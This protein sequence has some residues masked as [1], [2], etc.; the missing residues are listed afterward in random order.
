MMCSGIEAQSLLCAMPSLDLALGSACSSAADVH[1]PSHVLRAIG[2]SV[3]DASASFRLSFGR[4]TSVQELT[5][6]AEIIAAAVLAQRAES[7]LC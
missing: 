7:P 1:Q 4:F 2:L 5:K 6:A 3:A